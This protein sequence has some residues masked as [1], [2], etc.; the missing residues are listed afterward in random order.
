MLVIP[1]PISDNCII[2]TTVNGAAIDIHYTRNPRNDYWYIDIIKDGVNICNSRKVVPSSVF[3]YTSI[4]LEELIDGNI[5]ILE[6]SDYD[7]EPII[8]DLSPE[9]ECVALFGSN[10]EMSI[11]GA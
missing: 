7:E 6:T 10:L 9:G 2:N 3:A 11:A 5:Y 8:T 4:S 1:S